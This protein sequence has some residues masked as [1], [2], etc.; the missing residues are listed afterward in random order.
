[1]KGSKI[2]TNIYTNLQ[3]DWSLIWKTKK[4]SAYYGTCKLNMIKVTYCEINK[5]WKIDTIENM[6]TERCILKLQ[7]GQTSVM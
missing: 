3:T 2:R 5:T 6:K 7:N 1:M 4:S